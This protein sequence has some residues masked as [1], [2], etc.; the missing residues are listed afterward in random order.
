MSLSGRLAF[1]VAKE[2]GR[3]PMVTSDLLLNT[4]IKIAQG[5]TPPWDA[6]EHRAV[7]AHGG[8]TQLYKRKKSKLEDY[9]EQ[10]GRAAA[11]WPRGFSPGFEARGRLGRSVVGLTLIL[12][13]TCKVLM[14]T[15]LPSKQSI[16]DASENVHLWVFPSVERVCYQQSYLRWCLFW[17]HGFISGCRGRAPR[18]RGWS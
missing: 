16:G 7:F 10:H 5:N 3:A 17:K 2:E 9:T 11:A 1:F 6:T 4:P 8:V 13:G 14:S 18:L 12:V 15:E